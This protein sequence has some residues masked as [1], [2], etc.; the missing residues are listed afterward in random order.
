M[1]GLVRCV[2]QHLTPG[3]SCLLHVFCPHGDAETL[4]REWCTEQEQW[5]WEVAVEGGRVTCHDRRPRM[6]P[7]KMVLYPE[8]ISQGAAKEL[9]GRHRPAKRA[10]MLPRSCLP[11]EELTGGHS[12][13]LMAV[14]EGVYVINQALQVRSVSLKLQLHDCRGIAVHLRP[15]ES[16]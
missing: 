4:R 9:L 5:C 7:D 6:D 3:G 13:L 15:F 11:T 10:G 8:L 12:S 1:T 16:S 14:P 2:R